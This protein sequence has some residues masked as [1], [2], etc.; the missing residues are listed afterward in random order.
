V[1]NGLCDVAI[2]FSHDSDLLPAVETLVRLRGPEC[3]ETAAWT[4]EYFHSRLQPKVRAGAPVHHH[5]IGKAVFDRIATPINY[6]Y[7]Q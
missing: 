4:S 5:A 3:V 6:A 1:I 2:I 7:E